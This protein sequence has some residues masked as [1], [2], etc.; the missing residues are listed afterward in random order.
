MEILEEQERE[1]LSNKEIARRHD[2]SATQVKRWREG[3][4][5]WRF[6]PKRLRS[7]NTGR[8]SLYQGCQAGLLNFVRVRRE[9]GFPVTVRSLTWKL[10]ELSEAAAGVDFEQKRKWIYKFLGRSRLSIR[11]VTRQT[12]LDD[13]ILQER[14]DGFRRQFEALFYAFPG[15]VF[16]NMDQTSLRYEMLPTSTI[17]ATGSRSV[18]I[19]RASP[20]ENHITAVLSLASDGRKLKPML[21]YKAATNG[22]IA[23][24]FARRVDPYPTNIEYATS[25]NAWMTQQLMQRWIDSIFLPFAAESNR[26]TCLILDSLR[27]HRNPTVARVIQEHGH[28]I[29]YI[30]GGLTADV[31]PLDVGVNGPLKHWMRERT[32]NSLSFEHLAASEKRHN[33]AVLLDEIWGGIGQ[34]IVMNSFNRLFMT[35]DENPGDFDEV[36][37]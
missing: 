12:T 27:I 17:E 10:G 37:Q 19:R 15:M 8:P 33:L 4:A 23:R 36:D 14:L 6:K 3:R 18:R 16:V 24:E 22:R 7:L 34:D 1:G 2:L 30:P 21:I 35:V 29:L 13:S 9:E 26:P 25:P 28:Q 5:E 11:R 32:A 20:D 31:Q